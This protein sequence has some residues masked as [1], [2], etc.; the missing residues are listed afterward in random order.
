MK[1]LELLDLAIKT[2]NIVY[3]K[4]STIGIKYDKQSGYFL[5]CDALTG[6][7]TEKHVMLNKAL[8]ESDEWFLQPLPK[9]YELGDKFLLN[10]MKKVVTENGDFVVERTIERPIGVIVG[11]SPPMEDDGCIYYTLKVDDDFGNI[12]L[13]ESSLKKYPKIVNQ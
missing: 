12:V 3:E 1:I 10:S 2:G 11:I 5:W 13:G 6:N 8:I 7:T 9:K 4:D